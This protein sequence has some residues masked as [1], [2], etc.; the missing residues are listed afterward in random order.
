MNHENIATFELTPHEPDYSPWPDEPASDGRVARGQRTRR[1]V[2]DALCQLLRDGEPDPTAKAIAEQAG[3]SLRLVF[4]HFAD[5]DDLYLY[6]AALQLR[7]QWTDLPRVSPKLSLPTRIERIVSHR[8]TL[9]EEISPVR[10][11]VA[12]RASTSAAVAAAVASGER[13]LHENL[14]HVLAP[15]LAQLPAGINED[16]LEAMDIASSWEAWERMR[17]GSHLPVR[18]AK[19]VMARTLTVLCSFKEQT[20]PGL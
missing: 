1:N 19:R 8:T 20:I 3:V 9:Y 15:E 7:R 14:K 4:H 16:H 11:A 10:R 13:M 18:S 17:R 12:R 5:M 2:A 6:V